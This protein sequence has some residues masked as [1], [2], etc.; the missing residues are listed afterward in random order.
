MNGSNLSSC[1]SQQ[2]DCNIFDFGTVCPS[3]DFDTF[4][5]SNSTHNVWELCNTPDQYGNT[6]DMTYRS[7]TFNK[8]QWESKSLAITKYLSLLHGSLLA[9]ITPWLWYDSE[10]A[11]GGY[12]DDRGYV[13]MNLRLKRLDCNP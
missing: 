10:F 11:T 4:C 3:F 2:Y 1:E 6:L 9:A 7:Q 13:S 5:P 8:M 12:D